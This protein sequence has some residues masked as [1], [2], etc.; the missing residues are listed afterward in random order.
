[1]SA[2][3]MMPATLPSSTTGMWWIPRS[4][5]S[6]MASKTSA[7]D[8]NEMG[9]AVMASD[10]GESPL[11]SAATE[12]RMSRS[13]MMP[14]S[15][16]SSMT[17]SELTFCS[18]MLIAASRSVVR[19]LVAAGSVMANAPSGVRSTSELV[20]LRVCSAASRMRSERLEK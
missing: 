17:N 10:T 7:S 16:R 20:L 8:P 3:A 14:R 9:L 2:A 11:M 15:S 5:M 18:P 13:V 19:E 4:A 1:M 6:S 12:R